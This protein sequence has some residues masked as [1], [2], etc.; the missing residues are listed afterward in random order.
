MELYID[1]MCRKVVK[2]YNEDGKKRRGND[3]HKGKKEGAKVKVT[4]AYVDNFD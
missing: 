2:P 4:D 1:H 3:K